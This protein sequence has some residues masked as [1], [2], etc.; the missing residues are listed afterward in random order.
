MIRKRQKQKHIVVNKEIKNV[1][2]AA[3]KRYYP[4]KGTQAMN[5][6]VKEHYEILIMLALDTNN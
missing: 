5:A 1:A 4:V 2:A 6:W 3:H